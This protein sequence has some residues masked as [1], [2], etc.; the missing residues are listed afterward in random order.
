MTLALADQRP[1]V[2]LF[3]ILYCC[4]ITKE[5]DLSWLT[6]EIMSICWSTTRPNWRYIVDYYGVV[7]YRDAALKIYFCL[8]KYA[9]MPVGY[10]V[11]T[12]QI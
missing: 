5:T 2:F 12:I 3:E 10:C 8:N 7:E 6:K 9:Q 1:V 4:L 11:E